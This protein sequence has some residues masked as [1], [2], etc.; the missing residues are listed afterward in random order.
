MPPGVTPMAPASSVVERGES[1][2]TQQ[3][4]PGAAEQ[5]LERVRRRRLLGL[6]SIPIPRAG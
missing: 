3:G 5:P 6:Q 4:R 2:A 1:S